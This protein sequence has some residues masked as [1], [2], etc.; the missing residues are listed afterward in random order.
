MVPDR[1]RGFVPVLL[2]LAVF[3]VLLIAWEYSVSAGWLRRLLVPPPSR[4]AVS[5][6][7]A[8]LDIRKCDRLDAAVN[9]QHVASELHGFGETPGHFFESG[10]KEIAERMA[11][12]TPLVE[13]IVEQIADLWRRAE[14]HETLTHVPRWQHAK[15]IAQL[16]CRAAIIGHVDERRHVAGVFFDTLE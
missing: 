12:E 7:S 15:L 16:P 13:P 5:A 14:R 1:M 6:L 10:Q 9:F 2:P 8:E 4:L 11:L 3:G